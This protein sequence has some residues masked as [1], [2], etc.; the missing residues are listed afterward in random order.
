MSLFRHHKASENSWKKLAVDRWSVCDVKFSW[1]V[2]C[3]RWIIQTHRSIQWM[4]KNTPIIYC[5]INIISS[6]KQ[7]V[8]HWLRTKTCGEYSRC[9]FGLFR[10]ERWYKNALET[11]PTRW[12]LLIRFKWINFRRIRL[13]ENLVKTTLILISWLADQE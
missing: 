13:I 7:Y 8:R 4:V 1:H 2:S 6:L 12:S 3:V 5:Y 9:I 11:D 10:S